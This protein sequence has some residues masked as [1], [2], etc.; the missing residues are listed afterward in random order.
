MAS[1]VAVLYAIASF[2]LIH[3]PVWAARGLR[4]V[5]FIGF[6]W[7]VFLVSLA[8]YFHV[9]SADTSY[10]E[11]SLSRTEVDDDDFEPRRC[12]ECSPC[13]TKPRVKHCMT[14]GK[15]TEDFDH[16]CRYLNVCIGG[17]TYKPWFCFVLGLLALLVVSGFAAVRALHDHD[18]YLLA[19]WFPPGFFVIVA[20]EALVSCLATIFL[21]SLLGQ[22]VYFVIEGITTL[23]YV[24]DQ[25]AGFPSLPARGWR[26]AVRLGECYVCHEE[27]GTMEVD[28]PNEIWYCTVCQADLGKAGLDFLTCDRCDNVN[29][30]PLCRDIARDESIPVVTYR[31][32][33]L[34]RRADAWGKARSQSTY[35]PFGSRPSSF[36]SSARGHQPGRNHRR[37]GALASVVAAVEGHT[38]DPIR[39]FAICGLDG[40]ARKTSSRDVDNED[41]SSSD[42]G[43]DKESTNC[44]DP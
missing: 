2:A 26:E 38:G 28:D 6:Y 24:K 30:C 9:C 19:T 14:C 8:L 17:R 12:E 35:A 34:R 16:H 5:V 41:S 33:T 20:V 39:K 15:C 43:D 27:L 21:F 1:H 37:S 31:V 40:S 7:V 11:S 22:H 18:E 36:A 25:A 42:D 29:V 23:E 44:T 3:Q 10:R 32:T 4:Y 13:I